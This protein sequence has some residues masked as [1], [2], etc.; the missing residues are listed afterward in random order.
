MNAVESGLISKVIMIYV[1]MFDI[2]FKV[3][4]ET[5]KLLFLIIV[6]S[7]LIKSIY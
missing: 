2:V 3:S 5:Y 7:I 4:R 6:P 1:L